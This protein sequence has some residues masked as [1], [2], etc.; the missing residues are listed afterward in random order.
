VVVERGVAVV[1]TITV[2]DDDED[3][4]VLTPTVVEG[5]TEARVPVDFAHEVSARRPTV[6]PAAASSVLGRA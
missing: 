5:A 3:E 6:R 1:V 2:V 4:L